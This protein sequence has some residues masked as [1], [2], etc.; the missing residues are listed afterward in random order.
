MH[1]S[2]KLSPIF[3]YFFSS[4]WK[5]S[6]NINYSVP[7]VWCSRG[8][9]GINSLMDLVGM[10]RVEWWYGM[11][12]RPIL[13]S[14]L[15]CGSSSPLFLFFLSLVV[16]LLLV[17]ALFGRHQSTSKKKRRRKYNSSYLPKQSQPIWVCKHMG[18]YGKKG[19]LFACV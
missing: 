8:P 14:V 19:S 11:H 12:A 3:K 6:M 16:G 10:E 4:L 9:F 15:C 1:L 5:I 7:C 13:L 2:Q 18:D 17:G